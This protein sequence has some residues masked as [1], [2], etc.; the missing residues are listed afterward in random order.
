M[1]CLRAP[2]LLTSACAD[3]LCPS[4][5]PVLAE[6]EAKKPAPELTDEYRAGSESD[7]Y[8][9]VDFAGTR[10]RRAPAPDPGVPINW[11]LP[12][13][14]AATNGGVLPCFCPSSWPFCMP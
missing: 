13:A 11:D 3:A 10:G 14:S 9:D 2:V 7:D 1:P 8:D 6:E 12:L 4:M 5:L